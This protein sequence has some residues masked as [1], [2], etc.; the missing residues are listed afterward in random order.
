MKTKVN[1]TSP[2]QRAK[3][4]LG[5]NYQERLSA[6][7]YLL[8]WKPQNAGAGA[9]RVQRLDPETHK[10]KNQALGQ[11]DDVLTADGVNVLTYDQA[12]RAADTAFQKLTREADLLAGGE[13]L[14]EGP[15]TVATAWKDYIAAAKRRGVVGIKIMQQTADAQIIP[16][17]GAVQVTKLS[18][19]R[20][21]KWHQDLAESGKRKTGRKREEAEYM[22]AP[23]TEEE[24]R[25]RRDTANRILTNLKACLNYAL[26]TGKVI[27][28]APWKRVKPFPNTS[29]NRVRFLTVEEQRKLV[30]ACDEETKALVLAALYTGARYGE[31]VPVLVKD[32]DPLNGSLYLAF[33]KGK[34]GTKPRYVTLTPEG[35]AWF[36]GF[37]KGRPSNELMFLR[38]DVKRTSRAESMANPNQWATYDQIYAMEVASKAAGIDPVTFHEL[39]HTYASTLLNSRVSL[40]YV[41]EQLGHSDLRMVSKYYGHI[42]KAAMVTAIRKAPK[43]KL[44]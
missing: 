24:I 28:P 23:A 18:K 40:S 20:I 15:Y 9:W 37:T 29:S 16:T 22:D 1:L 5:K 38:K 2:T 11:A 10:K 42:A 41:A 13:V 25:K 31:L 12:K 35:I 27:E 19:A 34:G 6:G 7:S 26:D 39:R 30:A 14:P 17:L 21:E 32:F 33:G 8:Y 43:L 4:E 3:L 36:K 44:I